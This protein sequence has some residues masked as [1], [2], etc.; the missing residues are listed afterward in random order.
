MSSK[1]LP[2]VRQW[3]FFYWDACG[4]KFPEWLSGAIAQRGMQFFLT[5]SD[6]EV[7]LSN[8]DII[9]EYDDGSFGKYTHE[10]YMNALNGH[11]E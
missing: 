6:G 11:E 9:V 3:G 1:D 4:R 10:Q 5:T 7:A 2:I 8:S